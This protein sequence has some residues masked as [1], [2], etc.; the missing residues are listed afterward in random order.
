M[1]SPTSVPHSRPDDGAPTEPLSILLIEDNPGDARLFA[2]YLDDSPVEA[3]LRHEQTLQAGLEALGETDPDVLVADLGLPDSQGVQTVQ[4]LGT[5]VPQLPIVVLTGQD[6]LQAALETQE[7]GATEYLRK[8]D[9]TPA[10][11]GRTLRWALQ[12]RRMQAKL[13]QRDAWIR[14]ITEGLSAGIFRTGP[15]GHNE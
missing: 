6:D 11:V 2:E 14:S 7:A 12:R 5:A 9:L 3:T 8:E 4:A 10:L 13:R 15:T 1:P